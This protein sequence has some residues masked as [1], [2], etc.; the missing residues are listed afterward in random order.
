MC[1]YRLFVAV[2]GGGAILR[3]TSYRKRGRGGVEAQNQW[4]WYVQLHRAKYP[5][6]VPKVED[7]LR[8]Q[9]TPAIRKQSYMS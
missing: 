9:I 8:K 5:T 7:F 6:Q 1:Y 3:A 2:V 4:T